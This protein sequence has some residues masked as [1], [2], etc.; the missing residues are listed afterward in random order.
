[1][2]R[3]NPGSPLVKQGPCTHL[4]LN[5]QN[6]GLAG[7]GGACLQSQH[8]EAELGGP[9]VQ[10]QHALPSKILSQKKKKERK[11]KLGAETNFCNP[12]YSG[13]RYWEDCGSRPAHAKISAMVLSCYLSCAGS[14]NRKI[15]VQVH[16]EP[17]SKIT[18][19][20]RTGGV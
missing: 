9:R 7:C 18:K 20:R 16:Q 12:S 17:I 2:M 3:L 11:E 15:L 14:I 6:C 10:G 13:Y 4:S 5:L 8:L 19:A 1:M